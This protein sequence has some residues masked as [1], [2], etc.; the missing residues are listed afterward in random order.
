MTI[1]EWI[2]HA[3]K[4][5]KK[6]DID[7]ARLDSLIL[8]EA[9]TQK[10]RAYILAH[11]NLSLQ[12]SSLKIVNERLCRRKNREPIAYITGFKE[13]FG[14]E[15]FINKDV[16]IPRPE[17][18]DFLNLLGRFNT[19]KNQ[20]LLDVGTGS[21]CLAISAKLLLLN[22]KVEA[23]DISAKALITAKNNAKNLKADIKFIQSNLLANITGKYDY[24]FANL[25]YVPHGYKVSREVNFEPNGAIYTDDNGLRLIKNLG[26]SAKFNLKPG[27]YLFIESL[28]EQQEEIADYYAKSCYTF[29]TKAGL[30][31]IFKI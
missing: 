4:T 30:V 31:Q 14:H 12:G 16:M 23:C 8:L 1:G 9:A 24:I 11:P 17:T 29:C 21:G 15:F 5:L 26:A 2:E 27:G 13:F 6:A 10:D 7:S 18:E 28:L 20:K 19:N 22:L 3:T 25:P